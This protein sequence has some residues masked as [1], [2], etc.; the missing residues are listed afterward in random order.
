MSALETK[1]LD[2][3]FLKTMSPKNRGH[4]LQNATEMEFHAGEILFREG[5]PANRFFLIES[6]KV[7]LEKRATHNHKAPIEIIGEG[8]VLG[9][10]WLFPPFSWHFQARALEAT[11]AI[12][13]D[14]GHLLA[15][16]ERNPEFGYELMKRI[17]QILIRRL[18]ARNK[19]ENGREENA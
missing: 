6:G 8:D 18:E 17:S 1:I 10:S 5:E 11:H 3:P 2:H 12:V 9:W 19:F 7:A 4:L 13:L 15:T 14:G 16:G